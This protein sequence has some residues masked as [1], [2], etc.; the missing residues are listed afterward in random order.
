MLNTFANCLY[1][2][3]ITVLECNP[4]SGFCDIHANTNPADCSEHSYDAIYP[5][6]FK[7][8]SISSIQIHLNVLNEMLVFGNNKLGTNLQNVQSH[9]EVRLLPQPKMCLDHFFFFFVKHL[10]KNLQVLLNIGDWAESLLTDELKSNFPWLFPK[11]TNHSQASGLKPWSCKVLHIHPDLQLAT[12]LCSTI[13]IVHSL[14]STK[15]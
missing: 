8:Q 14:Y 11:Q 7:E 12:C 15:M 3:K 9:C 6:I 4:L 1:W 2:C 10:F 13:H 5:L